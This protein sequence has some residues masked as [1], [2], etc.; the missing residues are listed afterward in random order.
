MVISYDL[1][2]LRN[3]TFALQQE[4]LVIFKPWRVFL[5]VRTN[6]KVH[7]FVSKHKILVKNN[8]FPLPTRYDI[9]NNL[10]VYRAVTGGSSLE[11]R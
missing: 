2:H 6:I 3:I 5:N 11:R 8:K 4:L 1:Y 10:T 7:S 9:R